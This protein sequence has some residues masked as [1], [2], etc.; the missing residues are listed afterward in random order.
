[1]SGGK[2]ELY[3]DWGTP[4]YLKKEHWKEFDKVRDDAFHAEKPSPALIRVMEYMSTNL[5]S[6][7]RYEDRSNL[8]Y[9]QC[10]LQ[11]YRPLLRYKKVVL[12]YKYLSSTL[13]LLLPRDVYPIVARFLIY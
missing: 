1:M 13:V 5:V 8:Y 3:Y 10:Y 2:E 7:L 4:S 9:H 6:S 12:L 11:L